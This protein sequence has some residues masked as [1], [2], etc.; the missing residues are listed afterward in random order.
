MYDGFKVGEYFRRR[1]SGL[2]FE[3]EARQFLGDDLRNLTGLEQLRCHFSRK[4]I[5]AGQVSLPDLVLLI[6]HLHL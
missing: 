2:F 1:D 3:L 4:L 5:H 6:V